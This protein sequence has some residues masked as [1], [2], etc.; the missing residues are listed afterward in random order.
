MSVAANRK[1]MFIVRV[2]HDL[3]ENSFKDNDKIVL[4]LRIQLGTTIIME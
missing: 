1:A 4:I 3:V 2:I